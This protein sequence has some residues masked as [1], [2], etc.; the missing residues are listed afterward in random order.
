MHRHFTVDCCGR[1]GILGVWNARGMIHAVSLS[2]TVD[3]VNEAIAAVDRDAGARSHLTVA[4][5]FGSTR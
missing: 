4:L 1:R 3:A 5:R 2:E